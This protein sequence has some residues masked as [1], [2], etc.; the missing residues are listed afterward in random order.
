MNQSLYQMALDLKANADAITK[1]CDELLRLLGAPAYAVLEQ[2]AAPVQPAQP[3][4]SYLVGR[5][6]RNGEQRCVAARPNP[7]YPSD[8]DDPVLC[9]LVWLASGNRENGAPYQV[10]GSVWAHETNSYDLVPLRVRTQT[11]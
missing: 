11:A 7:A 4:Y 10:D 5:K 9:D 8:S 2:V 1:T 3:D 6:T